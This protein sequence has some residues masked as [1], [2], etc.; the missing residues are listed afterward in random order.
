[1]HLYETHL[2]TAQGSLCG[3]SDGR[4]Y[5]RKYIDLGFTGIFVTDHFDGG[6]TAITKSRSWRKWVEAFCRGYEDAREAGEQLGLDVFFG[7]EQCYPP[8]CDEYLIYGPEKQWL[9]DR[10]EMRYWSRAEQFEAIDAAGGCVVQAHPFRDR[11]YIGSIVLAPELVHG[12][13]VANSP[14]PP[15]QDALAYRYAR[16]M[17][18]QM[19]AGSDIHFIDQRVGDQ[20]FGVFLP[21]RVTSAFEFAVAV[22]EGRIMGLH[23]PE[24]RFEGGRDESIRLPVKVL[25]RFG[26]ITRQSAQ[27]LLL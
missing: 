2:H 21:E 19:T 8:E 5:I 23:V 6:N 12:I 25:D 1:M 18:L 22:R 15:G 11:A 13:E 24:A 26:N 20:V 14:N 16:R 3:L 10:P 17:G 27:D 9:I 4:D 7:W